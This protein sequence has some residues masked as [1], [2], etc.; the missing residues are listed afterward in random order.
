MIAA[1]LVLAGCSSFSVGEWMPGLSG[2]GGIP[3]RVDSEPPGADAR[4]SAGPG[5]R[6]PCVVSVPASDDLTVT[7]AL[8]GYETQ[9]VP[10]TLV[11][12]SSDPEFF[13]PPQFS[14]VLATLQPAAPPPAAK[15]K[16]KPKPRSA[17]RPA[18]EPASER[19]AAQRPPASTGTTRAPAEPPPSQRSIP[20]SAP[21]APPGS[22]WPR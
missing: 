11:R 9:T 12:S 8:A 20:G 17:T 16:G 6:T 3:L 15:R 21:T 5:C 19:P 1:S 7:F 10:A 2:G 13:S 14:P 22:A 4:T 18:G